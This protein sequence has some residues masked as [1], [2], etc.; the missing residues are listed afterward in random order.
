MELSHVAQ[1]VTSPRLVVP[2]RLREGAA[3]RRGCHLWPPDGA[4]GRRLVAGVEPAVD[5][6]VRGRAVEA[7]A[8]EENDDCDSELVAGAG[9]DVDLE[10]GVYMHMDM[11]TCMYKQQILRMHKCFRR[12]GA[13][14]HV[15]SSG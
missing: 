2:M 8:E 10:A 3:R 15:V 7:A 9:H 6:L 12:R 13:W 11:G 14:K 4:G 1:V 5:I